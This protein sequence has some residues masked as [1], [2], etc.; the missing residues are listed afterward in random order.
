MILLET[1]KY[2]NGKF[3]N[4]DLHQSRIN[5]SGKNFY[6]NGFE[7]NLKTCLSNSNPP[8]K[9]GIFKCRVIYDNSKLNIEYHAYVLPRIS[10]FKIVHDNSINY[11]HKYANRDSI[12]NLLKRKENCDDI[13]IVKN[14]LLTDSSY[15][16]IV[17]F[18][19][20]NWVTPSTPLLNGTK[21][22]LLL[23]N[24]TI[25]ER[26]INITDLPKYS[27]IRLINAM[28]D[29]EDAV[30]VGIEKVKL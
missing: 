12:N 8:E 11:A 30:E 22:E 14:G 15:A 19:G 13:I 7:A 27:K 23:S 9:K 10:S 20:K 1:I 24:K 21:R 29:F 2:L 28:I 3:I 6:G 26:N 25:S 17:L 4:L 18:D 5:L 16:N